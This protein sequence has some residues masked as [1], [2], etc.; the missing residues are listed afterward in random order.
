MG[1]GPGADLWHMWHYHGSY[2]YRHPDPAYPYAIRVKRL[3]DWRPGEGRQ[4][5]RM[6]WILLDREGRRFMNEYEPYLQDTG[7]R[8]LGEYDPVR[9][10]YPPH[11]R[12]SRDRRGGPEALSAGTADLQRPRCR[13]R[14]E[15]RQFGGDRPGHF[16]QGRRI[17][18]IWHGRSAPMPEA[19][20]ESIDGWNAACRAGQDAAFGRPAASMMPLAQPPFYVAQV[21]PVVSNTQGG[22]VHDPAHRVLDAEGLPI[23]RLFAA[24]EITSVFG[25]LY[26]SGGNL[27]ECFAGGQIAGRAAATTNP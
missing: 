27:A 25:H 7:H 19:V 10:D 20:R 6:A 21:H 3:P 22:L 18:T 8:P 2:G 9:Q 24:G 4:L 15:R 16:H 17:S 26:L 11:A 1:Q 5:P 12:L 23:A 13:L 14:L